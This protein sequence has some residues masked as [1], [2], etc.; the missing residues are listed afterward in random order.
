MKTTQY[1]PVLTDYGIL[2]VLCLYDRHLTASGT[3]LQT[4]RT[5]GISAPIHGSR[6]GQSG[7]GRQNISVKASYDFIFAEKRAALLLRIYRGL[8]DKMDYLRRQR[9]GYVSGQKDGNMGAAGSFQLSRL[10]FQNH[11]A[12]GNQ[13]MGNQKQ[14]DFI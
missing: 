5:G 11:A 3:H 2:S 10:L 9:C 8:A 6:R 1:Y 4:E 13:R 12:E 14:R 7:G